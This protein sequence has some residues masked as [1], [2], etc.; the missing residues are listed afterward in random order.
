MVEI[1]VPQ[2]VTI[3][4]PVKDIPQRISVSMI[5]SA[6]HVKTTKHSL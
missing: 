4:T 2:L 6:A 5:I 3:V 1:N